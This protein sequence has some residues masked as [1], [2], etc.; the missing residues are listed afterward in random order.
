MNRLAHFNAIWFDLD[1]TL[2]DT[3]ADLSNSINGALLENGYAAVPVSRIHDHI[4]YGV[5]GMFRRAAGLELEDYSALTASFDRFY[6][7]NICQNT[8]F[9]E[10]LQDT[11]ARLEHEGKAWGI[12]TNKPERF[13]KPLLHAFG[14]DERVAAFVCGDTLERAKP[15]PDTLL[16]ACKLARLTPEQG[17]YI[18]D[19]RNDIIAAHAAGMQA[20]AACYGYIAAGDDPRDWGADILFEHPSDLETFLWSEHEQS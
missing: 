7:H 4:S 8:R 14:L 13:T 12:I 18:G 16:H 20:A 11:L 9:F 2:L 6:L 1:G 19:S 15:F 10:P 17:L 3:A 5:L